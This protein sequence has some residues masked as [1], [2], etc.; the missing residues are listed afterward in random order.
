MKPAA[1]SELVSGQ[2]P[3]LH[4]MRYANHAAI[5][6]WPK[7]SRDA[8]CAFAE[9]NC[10]AGPRHAVQWLQRENELRCLIARMLNASSGD[11]IA[12]LKN[13]TEGICIITGGVD[14]QSGDNVVTT[15]EEF[16]T[17]R[18][19]WDRLQEQGV[20]IRR[21]AITREAEP[22]NALL[23]ALDARSRVL[24][25]SAV[26]WDSGFRLDLQKLGAGRDPVRTLFFVDAIQ[27]FG[28][29]PIDVEACRIDAL[30]AGAHKWQMGPEGMALFYCSE[31]LR[32]QLQLRQHGW[33]MLDQPYRFDRTDRLPSVTA[34]RFETGSPNT[35]GQAALLASLKLLDQAGADQVAAL[36]LDN[37]RCLISGVADMPG[38][39]L[40]SDPSPARRSAIVSL[41]FSD[42]NAR[43]IS[44]RLERRGVVTAA[45]GAGLRL[46]PHFYQNGQP[47]QD[48][49]AELERALSDNSD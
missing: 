7:V 42:A 19:A 35:M 30:A 2:F 13:T 27:Q 10:Q 17:N 9:E 37:T 44:R 40:L 4:T 45:R 16:V 18:L 1:L 31:R 6:P 39:M 38:V 48:L 12:L 8:V 23:N 26:Q 29:L 36:I 14:W 5:S 3:S 33:R 20:E 34:R 32:G 47:I 15:E 41:G 46:S 22:E 49:L 43:V 21:I 25:V 24:N 11:D 28:T